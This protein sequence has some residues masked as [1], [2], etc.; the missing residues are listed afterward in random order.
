MVAFG[1]LGK[2]TES[3]GLL[4][5]RKSKIEVLEKFQEE[6][7]SYDDLAIQVALKIVGLLRKHGLGGKDS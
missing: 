2:K 3:V 4:S 5:G 1:I 7:D 6:G